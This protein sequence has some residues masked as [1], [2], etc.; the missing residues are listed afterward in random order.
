MKT[1]HYLLLAAVALILIGSFLLPNAVAGVTDLRTFDNLVI[2]DSQSVSFAVSPELSLIERITLAANSNTEFLP[3]KTGNVLDAD[4]AEERAFRE[5]E[6]FWSRSV[7][8]VDFGD[9]TVEESG[10]S[11]IIDTEIPALNM[12]VWELTLS[13]TSE[14]TVIVT[15]DDETGV[16]LRLVCRWKLGSI[17]QIKSDPPDPAG[18]SDLSDEERHDF[19]QSIADLM[20]SY[21]RLPIELADY[22]YSESLS[23]YRTDVLDATTGQVISMYGVVRSTGFT[24]N[25]Q[26]WPISN[27]R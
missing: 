1:R 13:D 2:V 4:L 23:W 19:A 24:M 15:I 27:D 10:A 7:W 16:I 25:E 3:L 18:L 6:R 20:A 26:V 5:L 12:V 14:N 11:L 22:L 9:C 21:Y 8:S 17:S